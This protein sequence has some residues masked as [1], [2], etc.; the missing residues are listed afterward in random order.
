MIRE[1]LDHDVHKCCRP[2]CK[3]LARINAQFRRQ[4][5]AVTYGEYKKFT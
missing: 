5:I 4:K 2:Y 3:N 1:L